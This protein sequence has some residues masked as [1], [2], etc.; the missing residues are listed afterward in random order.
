MSVR[1]ERRMAR[2]AL[3]QALSSWHW[4]DHAADIPRTVQ[5]LDDQGSLNNAD[6]EFFQ[7]ALED[8]TAN[9]STF[10]DS[11]LPFL[12]RRISD[13]GGVELAALRSGAYEL[14]KH[15][16]IPRAIVINEWIELTKQFGA[17]DSFKYVNSILDNVADAVR[18]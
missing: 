1:K 15:H 4:Q 13:L 12:D 16:E 5:W 11:F 2:R 8:I 18:Q 14:M 6:R 7:N 3:L 10:D 9:H 17:T